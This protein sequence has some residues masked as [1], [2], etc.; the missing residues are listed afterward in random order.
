MGKKKKGDGAFSAA[1]QPNAAMLRR[2]RASNLFSRLSIFE[3][4]ETFERSIPERLSRLAYVSRKHKKKKKKKKRIE[5]RLRRLE[6]TMQYSTGTP[7]V[8]T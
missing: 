3:R 2:G 5:L 7:R 8:E 1:V 6:V 4:G